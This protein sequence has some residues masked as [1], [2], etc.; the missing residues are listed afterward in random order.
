M[1]EEVNDCYL[2]L[3]PI[4]ENYKPVHGKIKD[5]ICSP[6][7]NMYQ[8]LHTTVFGPDERL[9]QMQIRTFEMDKIASFGLTA[10]WDINKGNAREVMQED[11]KNKYQ[12]YNSLIEINKMFGDNQEFVLQA[13]RELFSDNIYVYTSKGDI[14]ELPKG[15]TVVDFAYKAHPELCNIMTGAIVNESSVYVNYVL[16]NKDRVRLTTDYLSYGPREEWIDLAKTTY[17][18][19]KIREFRN[20]DGQEI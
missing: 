6:K 7:T 20:R 3:R 16:N 14:I 4:H 12:F 2:L 15:S 11:L 9:V 8:S 10:Y 1:V 17:A 13:K 5:F 19:S 18:K